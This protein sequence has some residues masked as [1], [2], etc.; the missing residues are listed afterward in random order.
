[1]SIKKIF[2]KTLNPVVTALLRSPLHGIASESLALL[3]FRGRKSG[4][5]FVTPLSYTREG[6]TIRFMSAQTTRWWI[7]LRGSPVSVSV[8]IAGKIYPGLARLWE[9]DSEPLREGVDRFLTA[10][11]R[12]AKVYG[13]KLD[14]SGKPQPESIANVA[15][16]LVLVEMEL[17]AN[18][19]PKRA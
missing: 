9:G 6:S 13:I 7:N 12:D 2:Y 4:R 5:E 16:E 8:E 1:M 14:R 18:T 15:S 19:E 17:E 11:P 3:H 10:L